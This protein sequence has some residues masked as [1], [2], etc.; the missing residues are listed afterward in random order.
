MY[1]ILSA[2]IDASARLYRVCAAG[3]TFVHAHIGAYACGSI[4]YQCLHLVPPCYLEVV[5]LGAS[6]YLIQ[7]AIRLHLFPALYQSG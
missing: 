1:L 7:L 2:L 6:T 4:L 5:K 3:F